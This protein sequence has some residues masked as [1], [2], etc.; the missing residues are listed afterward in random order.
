MTYEDLLQQPEGK[1]LEFKE[2]LNSKEKILATIIA[3]SNTAGGTLFIGVEDKTKHIVGMSDPT[4]AEEAL[5]NMI[6]DSIAPQIIP[7]I[8][9]LNIRG[10]DL[11]VVEVSPGSSR[12]YYLKAKGVENGTYVRIGSSNRLGDFETIY[13][14]RRTLQLKTFDEEPVYSARFEE[15]DAQFIEE[16]FQPHRSLKPGDWY[17]LGL[18]VKEGPKEYLSV[19][20]VLLLGKQNMEHFPDAWIQAGRF[21]GTDKSNRTIL[22]S[23]NIQGSLILAVDKAM[24]FMRK[25]VNVS[26]KIDGLRHVES[27]SI[28]KM[29]LREAVINAL[30]H[31]DYSM[32]GSRI[33]IE[34]FDDRIEITNPGLLPFGITIEHIKE[35]ISKIRNRVIARVF[36]ELKMIEEFGSGIQR[37]IRECEKAGLKTP[38]FEE[39]G[40]S[41][42]VTLFKGADHS[43]AIED[44]TEIKIITLLQKKGSLTT[45]EI[46]EAIS[47]STRQ[48]RTRLVH[49]ISKGM[50]SELGLNAN[51]P[52][53]VYQLKEDFKNMFG[54]EMA[55]P[56]TDKNLPSAPQGHFMV[57]EDERRDMIVRFNVGGH[58][59]I[60]LVFSPEVIQDYFYDGM[61][62]SEEKVFEKVQKIIL[63]D[64][65]FIELVQNALI[66]KEIQNKL[67]RREIMQIHIRPEDFL[68]KDYHHLFND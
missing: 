44:L 4:G 61:D 50:I 37:I 21:E 8:A 52:K 2:N 48:T 14:L 1:T 29:A 47:L 30:I 62:A 17:T 59:R 33:R 42:R 46:A 49:M 23:Q 55:D 12:P 25:H 40:A 13:S 20:A 28:P 7:T 58:Q 11:I 9:I 54:L 10:R 32:T 51:D 5:A 35:G 60:D 16:Q 56:T 18:K 67:K 22:D 31:T 6:N 45:N 27:W 66:Q 3:F 38:V 24:G 43:A 64:S 34:I 15:V 19:G 26:L 39:L 36:R 57:R 63:A 68:K 41:F 53:K 65:I